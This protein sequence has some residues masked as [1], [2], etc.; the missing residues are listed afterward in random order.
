MKLP[1]SRSQDVV[2]QE[3]GD[4][5]LIYDLRINK[6]YCL[7]Q[8]AKLVFELCDGQRTALEISDLMSRQLKTPVHEELVWLALSDL[9]KNKL[10]EQSE[11]FPQT[12]AGN[13]RRELIKKVGLAS[14]AA[15]P[16]IASIVAP[17]PAA[18]QSPSPGPT[19]GFL[20]ACNPA[21]G[22][23][24]GL[25]CTSCSGGTCA[26]M[27]VCCDANGGFFGPQSVVLACTNGSVCSGF[28]SQCCSNQITTDQNGCNNGGTNCRCG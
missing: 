1:V 24:A 16:L 23:N 6:A 9:L 7:N 11:Q 21:G 15:L 2:V 25:G 12:L 27:M 14:M 3:A 22:C 28:A 4:E 17:S 13:T 10:I 26:G 19:G 8:T 5:I 18:A 20:Q